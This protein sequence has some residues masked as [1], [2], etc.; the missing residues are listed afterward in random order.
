MTDSAIQ[1]LNSLKTTP[2]TTQTW[3]RRLVWKIAI[4]TLL[5][6]VVGSATRV[7]NAGL[8]CPDWP[9]CYGQ[10]I[11]RQ[12]MNLQVF[13]EWFHR[14]DASLIGLS[15]L[16]LFGLSVWFRKQL[17]QWLPYAAF[18][19]L[20]LIIFQG[21][22]GGLTVTQLLRFDIVTAHLGTALLFL[23]TLIIMALC[24]VPSQNESK[25]QTLTWISLISAILIYFQCL[26]GGL[27]GSRWAVHQCL[28]LSLTHLCMVLNSHLWGVLPSTLGILTL[29]LVTWRT[30]ALSLEL[31]R[32]AYSAVGLVILQILLGVG[33][34]RLHLQIEPLTIAHHTI[35]ATLWG[36]L[37]AFTVLS[38]KQPKFSH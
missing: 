14:L 18:F 27:V 15:T 8:A 36:V 7:M 6:M 35:G 26:L 4:A 3:M 22:L 13:L 24:L 28:N 1:S 5:L 9:L 38:L 21:I 17:P 11:P 31:R 20:F 23:G 29:G 33:T 12:Q 2:S 34:F 10:L 19:A 30:P 25:P 16:S 32:L 37:V